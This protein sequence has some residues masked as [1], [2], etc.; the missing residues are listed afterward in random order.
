M[1][2]TTQEA[3]AAR[4]SVNEQFTAEKHGQIEMARAFVEANKA[5]QAQYDAGATQAALDADLKAREEAGQIR[6]VGT[7]RYRV[8]TGWDRNET[9]F[10]QRATRPQDVPLILPQHGLD[11][12]ANGDVALYLGE[13]PAWHQLGTQ[14]DGGTTDFGQV[15]EAAGIAWPVVK[16]PAYYNWNRRWVKAEGEFMTVRSDTG[17]KLGAVGADYEVIQNRDQLGWL[18]DLAEK[19]DAPF[20][21]AGSL[22][23]GKQV[24]VSMRIPEDIEIDAGGIGE[25]PHLYLVAFNWHNGWG[26]AKTVATPWRPECGNTAGFALRDAAATTLIRHTKNWRDRADEARRQLG[27]VSKYAEAYAAE[28][29]TLARSPISLGEVEDLVAEIWGAP[30]DKPASRTAYEKRLDT[31]F[32][33]FAIEEARVGRT[34]YAAENAITGVLDHDKKRQ[35]GKHPNM[36]AA[37]ATAVLLDPA[38]KKVKATAHRRLL[39]LAA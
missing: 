3:P 22:N 35:Q 1:S 31:V 17:E 25:H 33:R 28:E 19:Y 30:S 37:N 13:G 2:T 39:Q 14:I 7:D 11:L 24:F 5:A 21:S 18:Q 6:M 38:D 9:F 34:G 20:A 16:Q 10:V 27:M 26:S 15:L 12:K 32:A 8:L 36:A 4:L 23:G 29:T